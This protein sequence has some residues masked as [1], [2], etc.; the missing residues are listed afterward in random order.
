MYTLFA[1]FFKIS[2]FRSVVPLDLLPGEDSIFSA[3]TSSL[4]LLGHSAWRKH[5]VKQVDKVDLPFSDYF[6]HQIQNRANRVK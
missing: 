5:F 4:I 2:F 3:P 6:F 1:L